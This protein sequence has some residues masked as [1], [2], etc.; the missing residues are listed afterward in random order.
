MLRFHRIC[1]FILILPACILAGAHISAQDVTDDAL[2]Q[3]ARTLFLQEKYVAARL[4]LND[5]V[6]HY[7]QSPNIDAARMLLA[8]TFF[9]LGDYESARSIA[10]TLRNDTGGN[11]YTEWADYMIAACG[12]RLGETGEAAGLLARLAG[13]TSD[14]LLREHSLQ[15]IRSA[16]LPTAEP[17]VVED[18]L[19]A[20][21]ISMIDVNAANPAAEQAAPFMP[22]AEEWEQGQSLKIGL[23]TPLSGLNAAMGTDLFRGVQ[24]AVQN[25]REIDGVPVELVVKDTESNLMTTVSKTRELINEGVAVIIGPLYIEYSIPAAL[26]AQHAGIPFIS[27]T[28]TAEELT[29]IGRNVFQFN[30]TPGLQAEA[31]ANFA[32]DSLVFKETAVI[33]TNDDWGEKV[34]D[35]FTGTFTRL[36]GTVLATGTIEPGARVYNYD[37]ILMR[38]RNSA[39]ESTA[40]ADSMIIY[41]SGFGFADTLFINDFSLDEDRRLL[42]VDT[43]DCILISAL[44]EDVQKIARQIRDYSINTVL[45]GDTGWQFDQLQDEDSIN[46]AY[47]IS[48]MGDLSGVIGSRYYTDDYDVVNRRLDNFNS[49]KGYDACAVI[50]HCFAQGARSPGTLITALESVRDFRGVSSRITID[51]VTHR[52]TA[53][54]FVQIRDGRL[55]KFDRRSR[56]EIISYPYLPE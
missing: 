33:S 16:I 22:P 45:L 36:G 14:E 11:P 38:I 23:L 21:N 20:N 10:E 4:D 17:G 18:L 50:L 53:V 51:P 42:P 2:F 43:I 19:R 40:R 31:L 15:A 13:S 44:T 7:P 55:V 3:R 34:L 12:Y 25:H 1:L 28:V 54:D 47:I 37:D 29:D 41:D 48:S 24:L 26:E 5:L 32:A 9:R 49:R 30:L 35:T 56:Y 52:N 8:K 6:T 27:A 39:P 46:G